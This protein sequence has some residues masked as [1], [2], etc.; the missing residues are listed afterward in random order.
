MPDD[1]LKSMAKQSAKP[2]RVAVLVSG[3]GSN[4]QVLINATQA[5]ALPIEIVGVISNREDAYAITRA[6]DAAIPVAV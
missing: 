6:N 2:L 5:G 4:L 3:S 1:N